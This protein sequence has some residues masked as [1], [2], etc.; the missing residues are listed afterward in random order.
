MNNEAG[1]SEIIA[2]LERIT[3]DLRRYERD[4]DGMS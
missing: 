1:I 4:R 2:I 3:V